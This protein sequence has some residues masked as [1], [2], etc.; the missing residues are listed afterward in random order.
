[1]FEKRFIELKITRQNHMIV[2]CDE[3]LGC[4]VL[5]EYGFHQ[6]D[7]VRKVSLLGS[8]QTKYIYGNLIDTQGCSK[9]AS[10]N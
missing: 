1:M 9:N 8:E 3:L 10:L 2:I 5:F 6:Q 4:E 7:P